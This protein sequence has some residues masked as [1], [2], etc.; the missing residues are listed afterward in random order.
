MCR[1][2]LVQRAVISLSAEQLALAQQAHRVLAR[3]S[4]DVNRSPNFGVQYTGGKL[5][6]LSSPAS[7]MTGSSQEEESTGTGSS[8]SPKGAVC[9][10]PFTDL[11]FDPNQS[12][13]CALFV[14][15]RLPSKFCRQQSLFL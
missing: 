7:T 15:A 14:I 4:S 6:Y 8:N 11:A 1:V 2:R 5:S 10:D 12:P 13:I 3:L 9:V